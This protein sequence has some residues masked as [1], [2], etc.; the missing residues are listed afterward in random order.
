[1][2]KM[3]SGVEVKI[4]D[5]RLELPS[6]MHQSAAYDLHLCSIDGTRIDLGSRWSEYLL[7]A[8][9][10]IRCGTGIAISLAPQNIAALILP[11]SDLGCRDVGPANSPG[12]IDPDYQGEITVCLRN[13][14]REP[15]ELFPLMRIAQILFIQPFHPQFVA[16]RA[17]STST[18]RGAGGFGST[19]A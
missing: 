19:G 4:L 3:Y 1:M 17:F 18:T 12:L 7:A 10:T 6:R 16:V 9:E 8:G 15:V 14:S 13:F 11:R 5:E 2:E